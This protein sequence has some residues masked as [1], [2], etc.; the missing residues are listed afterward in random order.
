MKMGVDDLEV[1]GSLSSYVSEHY[2]VFDLRSLSN[3]TYSMMAISNKKKIILN[4][5]DLF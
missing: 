4:F 3:I 5:D 1:W 2:Q